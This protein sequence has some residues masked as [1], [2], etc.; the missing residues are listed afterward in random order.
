MMSLEHESVHNDVLDSWNRRFD[1]SQ[2]TW[3]S[4]MV[5]NSKPL[6]EPEHQ[7]EMTSTRVMIRGGRSLVR[8][9]VLGGRL[10]AALLMLV[11]FGVLALP[12]SLFS[13]EG[14][15]LLQRT[16]KG[17]LQSTEPQT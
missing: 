2:S 9:L 15:L 11:A 13:D 1:G 14:E 16:P 4:T 12:L 6:L 5:A 3:R 17:R 10:G 8:K 7:P